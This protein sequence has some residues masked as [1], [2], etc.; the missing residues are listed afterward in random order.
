MT[1]IVAPSQQQGIV[2][3]INFI[4]ELAQRVVRF[5]ECASFLWPQQWHRPPWETPVDLAAAV[6]NPRTN[7]RIHEGLVIFFVEIMLHLECSD[8][9]LFLFAVIMVSETC[10]GTREIGIRPGPFL[11]PTSLYP[12]QIQ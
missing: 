1:M 4:L 5:A 3:I 2:I 7:Q 11:P 12:E 8:Q 6:P 9:S 10:R